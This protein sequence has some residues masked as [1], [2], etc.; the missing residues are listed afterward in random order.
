MSV[1]IPGM[2]MPHS[3]SKCPAME[4]DVQPVC[5]E[6]VF[7]YV[8]ACRLA[9]DTDPGKW[10]AHEW[11]KANRYEFCPLQDGRPYE[12]AYAEKEQRFIKFMMDNV[13]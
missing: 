8:G 4:V 10:N 13:L 5:G 9:K 1:L 7:K 2:E 11:T 12:V 6:D 3:C